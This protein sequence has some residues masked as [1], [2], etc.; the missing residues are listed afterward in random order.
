MDH[1]NKPYV[2]LNAS[3]SLDGK[4]ASKVRDSRLSSSKDLAR[5]HRLRSRV[6]AIMVGIN[7]V[8]H[9]DPL[10]TV[11]YGYDA[12]PIRIIVDSNAKISKESKIVRTSKDVKTII[13]IA[14]KAKDKVNM[15]KDYGLD[16]IVSGKDKVDLKLLLAN[17]YEK[18]IRS[19]LLEG[20]GELN[21]SMLS[22][23]LVD[24]VMV[25]IEPVIVGGRD[26]ITLVEGEGYDLI[27]KALRLTLEG[28]DR[29]DDEVV[30][31]YK[32]NV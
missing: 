8:I 11:R 30:L 23:K 5:V 29:I 28:I 26:A 17:L 10:L 20:G 7:T 19:I 12:K 18:G 25:T 9:D 27:S 3:M 22:N 16:V 2:I 4:I 32:V 21:W 1:Y 15:L 13:A 6:D 24:E 31:R 14:S